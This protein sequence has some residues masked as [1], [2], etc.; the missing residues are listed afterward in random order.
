MAKGKKKITSE[1]RTV[2]Y[3]K[4]IVRD[5]LVLMTHNGVKQS[6]DAISFNDLL[7]AGSRST[8]FEVEIAKQ[9]FNGLIARGHIVEA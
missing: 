2:Q 4:Y 7:Y 3:K 5:G 1:S 6:G 8:D 9:N